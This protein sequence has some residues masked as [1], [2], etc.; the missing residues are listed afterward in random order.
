[1]A[2]FVQ[3]RSPGVTGHAPAAP[4]AIYVFYRQELSV[5]RLMDQHRDS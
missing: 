4:S 2:R 3:V 5:P 1:M